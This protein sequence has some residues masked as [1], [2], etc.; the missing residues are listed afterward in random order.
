MNLRIASITDIHHGAPSHTERG[1]A[2]LSLMAEFADWVN[3]D[4]RAQDLNNEVLDC[5]DWQVLLWRTDAKIAR[6]PERRGFNLPETDLLWLSRTLQAAEKPTLVASHVPVLGHDQNG[7]YYF[8]NNPAFSR[9]PASDRVR[10]AMAQARVPVVCIAGH[11]HWNTVTTID[12]IPHLTQQSLTE[13]STTQG[14]PAA[15]WWMLTLTE[16]AQFQVHG[17]DPFEARVTP[18]TGRWTPP[19]GPF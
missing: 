17:D 2:A 11:V 14:A 13:S 5:G 8:Q 7:N 3:E 4:I 9:Y 16:N 1:D 10:A 19:M 18:R 15:S 6:E 12:G